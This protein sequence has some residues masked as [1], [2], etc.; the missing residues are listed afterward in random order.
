MHRR[1]RSYPILVKRSTK[2]GTVQSFEL[3]RGQ[4]K[5]RVQYDFKF[6]PLCSVVLLRL[7]DRK[8]L[9]GMYLSLNNVVLPIVF[10]W[11]LFLLSHEVCVLRI[12]KKK[13]QFTSDALENTS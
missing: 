9:K 1:R 6:T 2:F 13:Q 7:K 5:K 3:D 12:Y 11:N 4:Y 10:Q 8:R